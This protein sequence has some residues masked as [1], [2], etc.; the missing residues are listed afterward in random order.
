MPRQQRKYSQVKKSEFKYIY[1]PVTSWR[2]GVSLGADLISNKKVCNFNCVYC[3]AGSAKSYSGKRR[4]FVPTEKIISELKAFR[5][6][7][8]ELFKQID[9]ITFSGLG[10]PS[11]ASNLGSVI[12]AI[13]KERFGKP[14]CVLTN[15]SLLDDAKVRKE[16]AQADFVIAK[17]DAHNPSLLD[18]INRPSENATFNSILRGLQ[19]FKEQ[20]KGKFALQIMFTEYNKAFAK[21]IAVLAKKIKPD[22]IQVNTPFRPSDVKPLSK[23]EMEDITRHFDFEDIDIVSAYEAKGGVRC[24]NVR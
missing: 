24:Q 13:K 4:V 6:Q 8:K 12:K 5:A 23:A 11:L 14:V 1:G 18:R 3:Q 17:L 15:A 9:Y 19:E 10:E 16:L 7:H 20:F 22:Q 21:D 2:I